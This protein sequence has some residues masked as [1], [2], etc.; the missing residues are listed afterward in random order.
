MDELR[1]QEIAQEQYGTYPD[2]PGRASTAQRLR[3][4]EKRR[5]NL[6]KQFATWRPE[7]QKFVK[8]LGD[9][10]RATQRISD[11]VGAGYSGGLMPSHYAITTASLPRRFI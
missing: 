1:A 10:L 3:Q 7:Y 9:A 5:L 8:S 6:A 11:V 4:A 2:A